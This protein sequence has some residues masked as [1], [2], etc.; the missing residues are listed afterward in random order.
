MKQMCD[1]DPEYQMRTDSDHETPTVNGMQSEEH[2]AIR[3]LYVNRNTGDGPSRQTSD[4]LFIL[5]NK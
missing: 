2:I 5:I 4:Q 3:N 1:E